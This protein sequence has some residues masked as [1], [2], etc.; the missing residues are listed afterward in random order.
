MNRLIAVLWAVIFTVLLAGCSDSG[1]R[2]SVDENILTDADKAHDRANPTIE[3]VEIE[4]IEEPLFQSLG[5]GAETVFGGIG[6]QTDENGEIV[7]ESKY[8]SAYFKVEDERFDSYAKLEQFVYGAMSD[9]QAKFFA[10]NMKDYFVER[11]GGLYLTCGVD[12]TG[13]CDIKTYISAGDQPEYTMML[14]VSIYYD[15]RCKASKNIEKSH[16][17]FVQ[18]D[19][20]WFLNDITLYFCR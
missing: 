17:N 5:F 11:D 2:Q 1:L 14:T 4:A 3:T 16:L 19:G 18:K 10:G 20:R 8:S 9:E 12:S 15:E 13:A 7:C 6:I